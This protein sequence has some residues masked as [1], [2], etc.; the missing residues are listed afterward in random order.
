MIKL[1]KF[2][3]GIILIIMT[4]IV[5]PSVFALNTEVNTLPNSPFKYLISVTI[6]EK[7]DMFFTFNQENKLIK[8]TLLA[9]KRL[10]EIQ[11]LEQINVP[12][13][14]SNI[15]DYNIELEK[16]QEMINRGIISNEE[17]RKIVE[18]NLNRIKTKEKPSD[19]IPLPIVIGKDSC[20][21]ISRQQCQEG[22]KCT[23]GFSQ[24]C[25]DGQVGQCV[26]SKVADINEQVI[27]PMVYDPVCG[28]DGDTYP[29]ECVAKQR[30]ASILKVGQ[31][32]EKIKEECNEICLYSGTINEGMYDSCSKKLIT[33]KQCDFSSQKP[34][35]NPV[36]N[37]PADICNSDKECQSDYRSCYFKC[38]ENKCNE[39]Y[40]YVKLSD[41]PSCEE[42]KPT[43][44]ITPDPVPLPSPIKFPV[45][46]CSD[47]KTCINNLRNCNAACINKQCTIIN[48]YKTVG[49]YPNCGSYGI[50]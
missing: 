37:P 2:K 23:C 20:N 29:N 1:P 11:K 50:L 30:G 10:I 17:A 49:N 14:S 9:E 32:D 47:D 6:P 35:D 12:I 13:S 22:Y 21:G 8:H 40:T 4:L 24:D 28:R 3:I 46:Q 7:L 48:S 25:K 41:Y 42:V 31:C 26:K 39:I 38:I 45:P 43:P 19:S 34:I 33:L 18:N 44:V 15:Q 16:I 36:I 27:C 5:L